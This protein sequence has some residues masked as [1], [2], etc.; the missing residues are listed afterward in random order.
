MSKIVDALLKIQST[1]YTLE[2]DVASSLLLL[3]GIKMSENDIRIFKDDV[4]ARHPNPTSWLLFARN[5]NGTQQFPDFLLCINGMFVVLE[6][7]S[8]AKCEYATWNSGI[9]H[10]ADNIVYLLSFPTLGRSILVKSNLLISQEEHDELQ[11]IAKSPELEKIS[12]QINEHLRLTLYGRWEYYVRNMFNQ[13]FSFKNIYEHKAEVVGDVSKFFTDLE[14]RTIDQQLSQ[15]SITY[16]TK[17]DLGYR[18]QWG[19]FFTPIRIQN[20]IKPFIQ[21]H[22]SGR[23]DIAVLEPS[24]GSGELVRLI[25]SCDIPQRCV[26]AYDI[27]GKLAMCVKQDFQD[28]NVYCGDFLLAKIDGQFDIVISNPPYVEMRTLPTATLSKYRSLYPV[29]HGRSNLYIP[30]VYRCIELLKTGGSGIFIVP[31]NI[32]SSINAGLLRKYLLRYHIAGIIDMGQ[33]DADV[34]QK[35]S[36]IF[37]QKLPP[38]HPQSFAIRTISGSRTIREC[39]FELANGQFVWNQNKEILTDNIAEAQSCV[40][41]AKNITNTGTLDFSVRI[42]GKKYTGKRQYVKRSS[43]KTFVQLTYPCLVIPRIV[44]QSG[45][46]GAVLTRDWVPAGTPVVIPIIPEN[47]IIVI[48][49]PHDDVPETSITRLTELLA[50]LKSPEVRKV[51]RDIGGTTIGIDTLYNLCIMPMA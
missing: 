51:V 46:K 45:I 36:V 9:P 10:R 8:S 17:T 49:F 40:L 5:P 11:K 38:I 2:E 34:G 21:M 23:K 33:F 14:Q 4:Y 42:S 16:Y 13:K 1:G 7:K 18:S 25:L 43:A 44:I 30:F 27:D 15:A 12:R 47:H 3:G 20:A 37:I 35:V 26:D 24:V 50:V 19:Q 6:C 31:T 29:I 41:Y 28:V 48:T 22:F 39:G 32:Q